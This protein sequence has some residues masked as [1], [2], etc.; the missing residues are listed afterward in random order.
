RQGL[1]LA[2]ILKGDYEPAI[3]ETLAARN[4]M[5]NDSVTNAQLG[6]AYARTGRTED[7]RAIL[8]G[9]GDRA[10]KGPF[11]AFAFALVYLGLDDKDQAFRSLQRAVEQRDVNLGLKSDPIWD[12]LRG[13]PRFTQVLRAANLE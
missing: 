8:K 7:A 3:A 4:V 1:G 10:A 11:P 2:Y 6:Y 9:F 12:P 13:D 5:E